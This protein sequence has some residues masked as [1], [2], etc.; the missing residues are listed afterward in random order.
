MSDEILEPDSGEGDDTPEQMRVRIEKLDRLREAGRAP[1]PVAVPRTTSISEVRATYADI[2]TD[3]ATGVTVS[4]TGRV[5]FMRTGGKLCFATLREGGEQ[6]QAMVSLDGVGE[7]ALSEWKA[8]VDIGDQV[9]I[10][11]EVISSRRGELS[12]LAFSW[13]MASK[14]LRPL[15][16]EHKP[17]SEES[18][19]RRRYV[20]LIVRPEARDMA[21]LRA[22]VNQS[23]RSSFVSRGYLEV[24]TP[25]LQTIQGGAAARPFTTHINAYDLQLYMRIA[26]EL[27]LKR[28]LV[29][30]LDKVFEI[31]R[32]FRNEGADS[33]HSPEFA[34]LEAYEAYG[35]YNTMATLIREYIQ[36]AAQSV[37]GSTTVT[38][39]DGREFDFG[40]EWRKVRLYDLV[41][42]ALGE[43]VTPQTERTVLEKHAARVEL[44]VAPK[45]NNG[46]LVEELFE[47]LVQDSLQEPTFVIDYPSENAP[48]TKAHRTDPGVSEKWDLYV[49]GFELGTAYS[50][51]NDP[52]VQREA[53]LAQVALA[54]VGDDESMPHDEDF[55]QALEYAMPPAGGLGMGIDRLLCAFTGKGIRETI[56]FPFVKPL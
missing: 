26:P 33:T 47:H 3:H 52:Q 55:L 45:W 51:M 43:E 39:A 42:D 7:L 1:Y 20:D 23:L 27:F 18:R 4:V 30:G 41:S 22:A 17:L 50:E 5:I 28:C 13:D 38:L 9:S 6:I 35:D 29:G 37:F 40:G 8:L 34:M 54:S 15:P 53:F 31:N 16:N 24:E 12:I 36:E 21:F 49:H 46:K 48:L 2:E 19:I 14:S 32:N 44:S 11:G 10:T 25:M 56:L